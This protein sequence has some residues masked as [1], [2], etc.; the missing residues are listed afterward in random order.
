MCGIVGF[1]DTRAQATE[2]EMLERG[3]AM[4]ATLA[5]RGPDASGLWV[6][7]ADGIVLAHTRLAILDLSADGAQPMQSADGRYVISYNG[8]AYNHAALRLELEALGRRF[9]GHSDTE[10]LL[11]AVSEWG[12]DETLRRVNGMFAFALYDRIER[13]LVLARDRVGEKP[14]YYGWFGGVL[15]FGSELKALR[16]HP[17]FDSCV[18]RDALALY[19]RHAYVPD[20]F[21]IYESVHKLPPGTSLEVLADRRSASPRPYWSVAAVAAEALAHPYSGGESQAIDELDVL[22]RDAVRLRMCADVPLGA[23]LSGGIDSSTVVAL[24]QAQSSRP[25]ETFSIG[26]DDPA[27]DESTWSRTVARYLGTNHHELHVTGDDAL[28]VVPDLPRIYDEPF[29]DPSQIPTHLL[30]RFTRKRVTV[31]LSGDAGDELFG[32]YERYARAESMWRLLRLVPL[33]VR[34]QLA[35]LTSADGSGGPVRRVLDMAPRSLRRRIETAGELASS[36]AFPELYRRLVSHW[37]ERIVVGGVERKT[38]FSDDFEAGTSLEQA[39]LVDWRTYLP[40]DILT[41]V[42]RASMAVSLECRVPLLDPRVIE[43]A[44][45]LP[46]TFK[47]RAGTTKWILRKLLE[48]YIPRSLVDRPKRGFTAPIGRWIRGELNAWA[49]DLLSAGRLRREGF[50][51]AAPVKAKLREHLRGDRD[52]GWLLWGVLVFEAWLA[53]QRSRPASRPP[54][55]ADLARRA[56]MRASVKR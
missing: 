53:E 36:P 8:E 47:H 50:L 45:R 20:P 31:S 29:A 37:R 34:S 39:M 56:I 55:C 16:E 35:A 5:H 51:D 13:R 2:S 54:A 30:S 4:A 14:L 40:G 17:A 9:R 43:L 38:A 1:I 28:R 27:I 7:P 48:R 22:L 3:A 32:G 10:V 12:V 24:M 15:L 42:D 21:C 46:R 49:A 33:G 44:W 23:F 26:F 52:W 41:K 25:I 6:E 19:L 11:E 18:D